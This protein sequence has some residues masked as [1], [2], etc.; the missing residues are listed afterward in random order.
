MAATNHNTSLV[1]AA[2]IYPRL[3]PRP[4]QDAGGHA[5]SHGVDETEIGCHSEQIGPEGHAL[6]TGPKPQ[7]M[8]RRK[9]ATKIPKWSDEQWEANRAD[10]YRLYMEKNRPLDDVVNVMRDEYK[11]DASYVIISVLPEY[12]GGHGLTLLTFRD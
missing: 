4:T 9:G 10:I 5:T 2:N 11:F 7:Q 3:A 1:A 12:L 8:P 6:I